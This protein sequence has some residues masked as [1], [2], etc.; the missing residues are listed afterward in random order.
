VPAHISRGGGREYLDVKRFS[1]AGIEVMFQDY[2]PPAY[3][4]CFGEFVPGL[5]A[6]DIIFNCGARSLDV[7]M[8]G[9]HV[10]HRRL[11]ASGKRGDPR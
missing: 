11:E 3:P 5:S 4:Q 6:V 2:R 7:I 8:S 10:E 1:L 9:N